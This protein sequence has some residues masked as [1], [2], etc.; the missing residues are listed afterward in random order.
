MAGAKAPAACHFNATFN[1]LI[2]FPLGCRCHFFPSTELTRQK[3][4][5]FDIFPD[6]P[7]F[8]R[9]SW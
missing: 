5:G 8:V 4:A 9:E 7:Q 6:A 3:P 1:R 2:I